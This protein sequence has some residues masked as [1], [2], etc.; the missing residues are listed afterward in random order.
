[1]KNRTWPVL[2]LSLLVL[3]GLTLPGCSKRPKVTITGKVMKNGQPLKVSKQGAI[4][5]IFLPIVE[6]SSGPPAVTYPA[7][8]NSQ[9]ATYEVKD[10]PTGKYKVSVSQF[11]PM[12]VNDLLKGQFQGEQSPITREVTGNQAIDIDVAKPGG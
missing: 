7:L 3:A 1:M 8:V 4:Q 2:F 11:D 10:I 9:E 6:G 5:V 12:P